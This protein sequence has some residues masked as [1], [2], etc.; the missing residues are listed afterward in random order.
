MLTA[1]GGEGG[2]GAV[3]TMLSLGRRFWYHHY[4]QAADMPEAARLHAALA[5][6]IAAADE[7]GAAAALDALLD[8]IESFTRATVSAGA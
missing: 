4:R 6:A 5:R 1:G 8:N 2:G 7:R 3:V